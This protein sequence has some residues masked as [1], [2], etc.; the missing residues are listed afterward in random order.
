[1]LRTIIEASL[2]FLD[3]LSI[4]LFEEKILL[5]RAYIQGS[6]FSVLSV[7]P[8]IVLVV[9]GIAILMEHKEDVLIQLLVLV[10]LAG[11]G[12]GYLGSAFFPTLLP[13]RYLGLPSAVMLSIVSPRGIR[14][15]A[16]R[17]RAG[18]YYAFSMVLLAIISFGFAGTLM[19]GNPYT[20]S[21]YE[22]WSITGLIK[23][24][25]AQE[26]DKIVSLL[27]CNNYLIDWRAGVYLRFKYLW[28]QPLSKGFYYPGT[29][30]SFILAGYYGLLVTPEYL[31][32][33]NGVLVLRISA[34]TMSDSFAPHILEYIQKRTS[35]ENI[36]YS[37]T[38]FL[39][40]FNG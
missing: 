15:L 24:N 1:V 33:F 11:L 10:S 38:N 13:A 19:P 7:V 40:A 8:L 36:I 6:I 18:T 3:V 39:I 2:R 32:D 26:L 37:S 27:C 31:E 20:V 17:G 21:A 9:L 23:Y 16:R 34:L 25:E 30:S 29:Q 5:N 28:I 14:A 4:F 22:A 35:K 12:I